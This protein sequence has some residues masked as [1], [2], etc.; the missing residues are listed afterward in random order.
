[1]T[2]HPSDVGAA[3]MAGTKASVFPDRGGLGGMG[4]RGGV[5]AGF[6]DGTADLSEK[7][8]LKAGGT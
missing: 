4:A 6:V 8:R 3:A 7:A 5:S 2:T 1:L